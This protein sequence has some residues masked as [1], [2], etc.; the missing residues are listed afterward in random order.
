M[1]GGLGQ[2][3]VLNNAS[4]RW[5]EEKK[6]GQNTLSIQKGRRLRLV[7]S[8][9]WEQHQTWTEYNWIVSWFL[10][11]CWCTCSTAV[12]RTSSGVPVARDERALSATIFLAVSVLAETLV[13][14]HQNSSRR[15]TTVRQRLGNGLRV[16]HE[17]RLL[18][19][20]WGSNRARVRGKNREWNLSLCS[21]RAACRPWWFISTRFLSPTRGLCFGFSLLAGTG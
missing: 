5:F 1:A 14:T 20:S 11:H 8:G 19:G 9:M 16:G 18:A 2:S 3:G 13:A 10:R 21:A 17:A 7:T 4:V 6:R 15:C 12:W